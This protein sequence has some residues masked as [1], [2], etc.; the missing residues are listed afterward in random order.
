MSVIN[1]DLN[2]SIDLSEE[3]I[4][5]VVEDLRGVLRKKVRDAAL[6]ELG[7]SEEFIAMKRAAFRCAL[8][9]VRK[10]LLDKK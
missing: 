9:E 7:S 8:E 2:L 6:S 3:D 1:I 5:E 4:A 10:E